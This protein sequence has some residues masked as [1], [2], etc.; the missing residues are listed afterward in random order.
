MKQDKPFPSMTP[1]EASRLFAEREDRF[2]RFGYDLK[3]ERDWIVGA[4]GRIEGRVLEVGTGKGHLTLA[5]ARKGFSVT[6]V[7]MSEEDQ[8]FAR[9]IVRHHG[10]E[11]RVRFMAQDARRMTFRDGEFE[12]VVAANL[13]H[14]LTDPFPVIEDMI[15]VTAGGGRVVLSDFTDKGFEVIDRI[16]R[17]EG[18]RHGRGTCG[19]EQVKDYL[20]GTDRPFESKGTEIQDAVI[21]VKKSQGRT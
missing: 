20:R 18:R 10:L 15:R 21:L 2:R 19:L 12:L 13:V 8:A 7:D 4:C 3:K 11:G 5:L 14:H 17:S 6:T 1:L 9:L 16:H